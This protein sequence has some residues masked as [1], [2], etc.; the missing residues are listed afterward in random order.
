MRPKRLL[1]L[2]HMPIKAVRLLTDPMVDGV[3]W[4]VRPAITHL[5]QILKEVW[6]LRASET[7]K[8]RI[9]LDTLYHL[10]S[11]RLAQV[12][13]SIFSS[14]ISTT[15][16]QSFS[17]TLRTPLA[18]L[19]EKYI[20]FVPVSSRVP[21]PVAPS[22]SV[23]SLQE[24]RLAFYALWREYSINNGPKEQLFAVELGYIAIVGGALLFLRSGLV[25]NGA[26]RVFRTVVTQQ[27]IVMKVFVSLLCHP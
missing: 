7:P 12:T 24:F 21:T 4:F 18:R 10:A 3:L 16:S 2:L 26:T 6:K 25:F 8:T 14:R 15:P 27:L 9:N 19:A 20:S 5:Y 11:R 23:W 22:E 1:F 13:P 17:S